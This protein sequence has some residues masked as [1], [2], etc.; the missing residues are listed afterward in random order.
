MNN[1]CKVMKKF[2]NRSWNMNG[3]LKIGKIKFKNFIS[4]SNN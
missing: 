3:S 2:K 1:R 4:N